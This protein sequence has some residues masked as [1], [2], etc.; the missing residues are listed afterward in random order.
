MKKRSQDLHQHEA[1]NEGTL[2]RKHIECVFMCKDE[3]KGQ[4]EHASAAV[5]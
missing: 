4:D 5:L 3:H 2:C 1:D